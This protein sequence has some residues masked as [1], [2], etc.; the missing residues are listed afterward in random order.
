MLGLRHVTLPAECELCDRFQSYTHLAKRT[1]YVGATAFDLK[2]GFHH[3]FFYCDVLTWQAIGDVQ[4]PL[5]VV[6]PNQA[7]DVFGSI[8]TRRFHNVRYVKVDKKIF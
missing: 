1:S 4:A 7:E 3:L 6:L 5:L 2:R 8:V